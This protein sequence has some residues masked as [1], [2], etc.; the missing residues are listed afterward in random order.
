LTHHS[1]NRR[2]LAGLLLSLAMLGISGCHK[3]APAAPAAP[4]ADAPDDAAKGGA[5]GLNLPA[6]QVQKLGIATEAAK[7]FS[8][9]PE[10]IGYGVIITH[11]SIATAVAELTTAQAAE[12]QSR[13]VAARA[14]RLAGTS[15]AMAA[16]AVDNATR[17]SASD[18]AA[19]VLAERRL[20]TVIGEGIPGG[21]ANSAL[22][23][24]L[25]S[26]KAKL[27][28]ASFALGVLRGTPTRLRAAPLDTNQSAT[29]QPSRN[30]TVQQ[31]WSAPADPS[32][33]GRSFFGVLRTSDAGEG[34]RLLV[35]APGPQAA[36][37]GVTVPATAVVI[38]D[39]KYW[40]YVED[41][42][43]HYLRRE[44]A[45]DKPVGA[46][47]FVNQGIAVGDKVVTAQAGLL[48]ARETNPSTEAD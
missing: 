4:A 25:A 20:A 16:D 35:W 39:G 34:E 11:D 38:S 15:G 37:P 36:V 44:V 40:C 45:T 10:V 46:D 30:W 26:G 31:I 19:L 12:A 33:P 29:A 2:A 24:E 13:A 14:Q 41:K 47:Y 27:L 7:S 21:I 32:L 17:Q 5:E 6:E 42:P 3:S 28:R 1:S 9:T 18:N 22:L 8:Y 23:Q 43:G 48:L